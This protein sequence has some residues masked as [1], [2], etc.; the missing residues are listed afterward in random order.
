MYIV[1]RNVGCFIINNYVTRSFFIRIYIV[2]LSH[3][4]S[5]W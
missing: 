5:Y 1:F 2:L 3:V 4:D